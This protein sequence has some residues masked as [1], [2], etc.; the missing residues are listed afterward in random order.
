MLM[1]ARKKR[2]IEPKAPTKRR[3]TGRTAAPRQETDVLASLPDFHRSILDHVPQNIYCTDL[4]GRVIYANQRYCKAI[5]KPLKRILGKTAYDFFPKAL[6]D[7]YA[8]DDRRVIRTGQTLDLEEVN[9]RPRHEALHVRVVKAPLRDRRGRI[10]GVQGTFWD[11]TAQ[12]RVAAQTAEQ[13]QILRTLLDTVPDYIY[14][15]DLQSR[16]ILNSRAHL[17]LLGLTDQ[18]DAVGKTDRDFFV[19]ERATQFRRDEMEV[20]RTGRAIVG[21]EEKVARPNG[22]V[23]WNSTTKMPWRDAEGRI[24]GTMGIS[25]DITDRKQTENL[26]Y[27]RAFYDPLT[28]LPNRALFMD[29]LAYFFHR[30]ERNPERHFAVLFL[31]LDRFKSIND[32][33]GHEA[34]DALLIATAQ[35]LK[36]CLRPGDTVARLGG[37]EFTVL[38]EEVHGIGDAVRVAKRILASLAEPVPVKGTE[39]FSTVSIGVALSSA[40]YKRPEDLLRDADTAMYGAK[41]HGRSRYEVFDRAMHDRAVMLLET[42]TDLRRALDRGEFCIHYQP[43]VRLEDRRVLGFEALVRW[44]H[45]QRGLL[46]PDQFIALAEELGLLGPIGLWVLREA[47]Q[48]TREWQKR[49]PADPPLRIGVNVSSRQLQQKGFLEQVRQ[50]L[51][52]TGLAPGSLTLE[53]T[54]KTLLENLKSTAAVLAQLRRLNIQVHI[55]DFGTDYLLL[56]RLG[57]YPADTLKIDPSFVR[58]I[59]TDAVHAEVMSTI[60]R[61]AQSLGMKV[62]A[63]GVETDAQLKGLRDAECGSAQ[64]FLFSK[65]VEAVAA[66]AFLTHGGIFSKR[67]LSKKKAT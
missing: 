33:L 18:A 55:D 15:K 38:L 8:R 21:K 31:D 42:E 39:V 35:K 54:E 26:L 41:A 49:Y 1:P 28:E 23:V 22:K 50:T 30:A 67:G 52:E 27:Q 59:G 56:R 37:D 46:L 65:A 44:N 58:N 32:S 64:G 12:R 62:M 13:A 20:L 57:Q 61:L 16:F 11:V 40:A 24:A 45:P 7:K 48:Q 5:G 25:R 17:G 63:E 47:C 53:V 19:R 6:A 66:E 14:F 36:C 4:K 29:R 34:G 51:K 10:V 43:V 2:A 3:Q 60:V 9:Q